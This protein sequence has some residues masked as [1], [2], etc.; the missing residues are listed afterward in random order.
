VS[1]T[2]LPL[3]GDVAD[4]TGH[5]PVRAG[6]PVRLDRNEN[7]WPPPP[8]PLD[9]IVEQIPLAAA[10]LHRYPDR[11]AAALR[12]ELAEYLTRQ[13]DLLAD[14][15][16]L[17]V[18]NG[19]NKVMR[20]IAERERVSN[21]LRTMGFDVVET[22]ANFMLFGRLPGCAVAWQRLLELGVLVRDVGPRPPPACH[23]RPAPRQRRP[24]ARRREPHRRGRQIRH[25]PTR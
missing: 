11:A 13:T 18:A 25:L 19:S 14:T 21:A 12:G 16:N 23:H 24:P 9:S 15:G 5:G 7:P 6:A 22:D 10:G 3:R 4:R 8:D 1:A 17:R 2:A 20:L